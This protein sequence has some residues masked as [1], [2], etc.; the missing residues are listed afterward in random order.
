MV[1]CLVLDGRRSFLVPPGLSRPSSIPN[2][3]RTKFFVCHTS[4]YSRKNARSEQASQQEGLTLSTF[5]PSSCKLPVVRSHRH[6]RAITSCKSF[7]CHTSGK[8]AH[9]SFSCHTFSKKKGAFSHT[10]NFLAGF[11][12]LE[13]FGASALSPSRLVPRTFASVLL[14]S[15]PK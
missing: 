5:V 6:R 10:S 3:P 11:P 9:K 1:S 14:Y 8:R 2:P 15:I 7:I 13:R 4:A 12:I